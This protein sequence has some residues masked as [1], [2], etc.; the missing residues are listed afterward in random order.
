[1]WGWNAT[2]ETRKKRLG[3]RERRKKEKQHRRK[4]RERDVY[5]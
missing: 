5:K 3:G 1:M 2:E 4:G